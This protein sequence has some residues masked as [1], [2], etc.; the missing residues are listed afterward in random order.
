VIIS[1]TPFRISF[2]GGGTDYPAWFEHEK[3]AVLVTTI[4]KYCYVTC[5]PLP[6]FF[7]HRH[8][9]VYSRI[10]NASE[11]GELAHPTVREGLRFM[12]IEDGVE[13]HHDGDLPARAGLGSSSAFTVGLLNSLY[14][15]QGRFVPKLQ[16]AREATY[17]ERE[18]AGEAV[19]SQDPISTALGGFNRIEFSSDAE[20][21]I[22]P[23][24]LLGARQRELEDSLLLYF[25]G[26]TR[27]ASEIAAEQI[28]NTD[29]R[30]RE[31]REMYGM[32]DQA[33]S[34][35]AS[36]SDLDA[37]GKLLHESWMR[38]RTLS[39]CVT[40][41]R[42]DALYQRACA[43]GAIG[44]KLLGA[45]GGG[46]LLLFARP[47]THARIDAALGGLLRVPFRSEK[48][49]TQIIFYDESSRLSD[50]R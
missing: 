3:G 50:A 4:D 11:I 42:I 38:K 19:G 41:P 45:G 35:L 33:I 9:I 13:I 34:I 25:T 44:G 21:S 28:R 2:F 40:T 46:F 48:H 6:P 30:R 12:R 49:G 18:L 20:I 47:D 27:I 22:D 23:L 31:L 14:A 16:L 10:E 43:S 29:G 36:D 17:V 1:R 24:P 15:M 26:F 32:V 37:F 7:E 8:R 5:R 39:S